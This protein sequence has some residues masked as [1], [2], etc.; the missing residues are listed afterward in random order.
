MKTDANTSI[1]EGNSK[2]TIT[3]DDQNVTGQIYMLTPST[4]TDGGGWIF[5]QANDT[6]NYPISALEV[7]FT[8][9][10][11]QS[12]KLWVVI[13]DSDWIFFDASYLPTD[14]LQFDSSSMTVSGTKIANFTSGST[15]Y[16]INTPDAMAGLVGQE[17]QNGATGVYVDPSA[18]TTMMPNVEKLKKN[19]LLLTFTTANECQQ[20]GDLDLRFVAYKKVMNR[21]YNGYIA[22]DPQLTV[23]CK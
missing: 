6:N 23:R 12:V 9:T 2:I 19:K 13:E 3:A 20:C 21:Q 7:D 17:N 4:S 5:R 10:N 14:G 16:T 11:Q 15:N 8:A 22:K 18:D 1:S